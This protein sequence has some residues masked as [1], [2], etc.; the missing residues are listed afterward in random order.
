MLIL[1][2]IYERYEQISYTF[3]LIKYIIIISIILFN[4]II[5]SKHCIHLSIVLNI[6]NYQTNNGKNV[7]NSKPLYIAFVDLEKAF[8]YVSWDKLFSIME[9]TGLDLKNRKLIHK[10]YV[11]ERAVI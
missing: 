1:H 3:K 8:D 4:T 10:L 7:Q 9:K 5:F 6:N 11:T 2:G